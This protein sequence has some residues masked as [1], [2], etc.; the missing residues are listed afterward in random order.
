M[1]LVAT[2]IVLDLIAVPLIQFIYDL[3]WRPDPLRFGFRFNLLS[4]G[5]II[6]VH[7][8]SAML[9]A[10]VIRL[11]RKSSPPQPRAS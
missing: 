5:I 4:D 7:V 3:L 2:V 6:M 10:W 11:F 9:L 8:L 1:S